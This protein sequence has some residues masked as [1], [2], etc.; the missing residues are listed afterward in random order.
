M[1]TCEITG[2]PR[3]EVTWYKNYREVF[4][5]RHCTVSC[6]GIKYTLIIKAAD[7]KDMGGIECSA[8]NKFGSVSCRANL[9][10]EGIVCLL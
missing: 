9:T 6:D 7:S 8:R 4:T 3:P 10:V 1:F 2:M 5:G